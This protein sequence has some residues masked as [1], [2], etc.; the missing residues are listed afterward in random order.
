MLKGKKVLEVEHILFQTVYGVIIGFSL[1]RFSIFEAWGEELIFYIITLI[2]AIDFYFM[3]Y[4][5]YT[6]YPAKSVKWIFIHLVMALVICNLFI[7]ISNPYRYC[8]LLSVY[9]FIDFMWC[10]RAYNDYRNT[11]S[12]KERNMFHYFLLTDIVFTGLFLFISLYGLFDYEIRRFILVI[13][14]AII[15][16][17][18]ETTIVRKVWK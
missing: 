17:I 2:I 11:L 13:L 14:W 18:D 7:E 6:R 15:R 3:W 5:Y 1:T 9:W 16:T 4:E 10:L 8:L 12:Q